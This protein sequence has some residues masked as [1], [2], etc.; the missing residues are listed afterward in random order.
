ME[1]KVVFF[2]N[3]RNARRKQPGTLIFWFKEFLDEVGHD[4]ATLLMHTDLNDPHGQPLGVIAEHLG[5]RNGQIGFS[6]EKVAPEDLSILYNLADCTINISDAEGFGLAT[7]ESLS[8]ET[9]I[10]VNMTGGLQ[11]QVTDGENWFG[12]GLEPKSKSVIGS[13]T[14]P[15]IHEDRLIKEDFI[16]ALK[17]IY[18]MSP[19]DRHKLGKAGRAHVEKNYNFSTFGTQWVECMLDVHEKYGSWENRKNYTKWRFKKL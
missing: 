14:V 18:N 11:E 4:K 5:L 17:K 12:I 19:E 10:I 13:Q 1:D 9:P 2:W 15:W 7:L 16:A 8:C 3:N 6:I